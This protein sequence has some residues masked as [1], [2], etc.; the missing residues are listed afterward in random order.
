MKESLFWVFLENWSN[1]LAKQSKSIHI[2]SDLSLTESSEA[3]SLSVEQKDSIKIHREQIAL[4][5][6]D[7][8]QQN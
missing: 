1:E 8:H 7:I 2:G 4:D 6:V 5:E 3:V